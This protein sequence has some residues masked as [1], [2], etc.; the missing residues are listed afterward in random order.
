M[1][2]V[3]RE[4]HYAP[5]APIAESREFKEFQELHAS[6]PGYRGTIVVDT[7]NGRLLTLTL[8]DT[9]DD[10]TAARK[11]LEPV[12]ERL[13]NPLMTAPSQLLGTGPVVV[14]DFT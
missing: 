14:D 8:W 5:D 6:R 10:M 3:V 2:A 4:T 9:A 12:V 7:G 11:A 13:L 1:H